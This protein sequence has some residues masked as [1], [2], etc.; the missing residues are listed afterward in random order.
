MR[1]RVLLD[2]GPLVAL[3]DRG[4]RYHRWA[5]DQFA[6]IEPPLLT[7]EAVITESWHLLR[8]FPKGRDAILELLS[9]NLVVIAFDLGAEIAAVRKLA[10]RYASVPMSL[11]DSCLVRMS[12]LYSDSSVITLDSDFSVYRR[13]SRQVIP[14]LQP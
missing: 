8:R 12:E 9:R 1:R 4:D 14:L 2:T 7:C 3:L 10:A 5:R 6:N 11:A 13:H